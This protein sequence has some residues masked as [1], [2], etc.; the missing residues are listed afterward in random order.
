MFMKSVIKLTLITFAVISS[1]L[2][3]AQ[4]IS[5]AEPVASA[6]STIVV[7][8]SSS[9]KKEKQKA[10]V[11]TG[12]RFAYPLIQKWIDDYSNTNPNAQIVIEARGSADPA[13]YDILVEAY[14]QDAEIKKTRDYTNVARYAI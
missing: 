8:A 7:N 12:A 11:I 6:A 14:D 1:V 10:V 4:N 9:A 13:Q 5:V 3:Q 2:T